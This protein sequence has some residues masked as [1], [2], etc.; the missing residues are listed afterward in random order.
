MKKLS[1]RLE[2]LDVQ[3]FPTSET[4]EAIR[5]TVLGAEAAEGSSFGSA[6]ALTECSCADCVWTV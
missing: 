6:I 1:L 2:S 4:A 5:G 3:S